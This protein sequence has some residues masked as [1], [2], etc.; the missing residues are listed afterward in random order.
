MERGGHRVGEGVDIFLGLERDGDFGPRLETGSESGMPSDCKHQSAPGKHDDPLA[1][2]ALHRWRRGNV[3]A[4][5][6]QR[7]GK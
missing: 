1:R 3:G 7:G 5:K 6:V 4:G 2:G